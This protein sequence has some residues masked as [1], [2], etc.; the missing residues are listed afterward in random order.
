MSERKTEILKI[1]CTTEF[2]KRLKR[3]VEADPDA[4]DLSKWA[5]HELKVGAQIAEGRQEAD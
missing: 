2:K 3:I 4:E 5:R 1:R